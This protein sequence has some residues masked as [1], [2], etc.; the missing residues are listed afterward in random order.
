MRNPRSLLPKGQKLASYRQLGERLAAFLVFLPA[1][2]WEK[3]RAEVRDWNLISYLF[4]GVGEWNSKDKSI[5]VSTRPEGLEAIIPGEGNKSCIR[6]RV[7][8]APK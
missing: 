8:L 5:S 1:P 2:F 7:H 4:T 3:G 6:C